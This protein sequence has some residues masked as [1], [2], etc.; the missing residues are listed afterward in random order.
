MDDTTQ[1]RRFHLTPG[2][3]VI[4]LLAVEGL[5]WLSDRFG[6]L[7]WH[8]GY[9]VLT[10]VASVGV[11]MLLMLVWFGVAVFFRRRFQFSIR[12]LLVLTVAVALPCSWL[13]VEMEKA[14]WQRETVAS[15]QRT[16]GQVYYEH[17]FD[18]SGE[19][20]P[21]GDVVYD[22][23]LDEYGNPIPGDEAPGAEKP[24]PTWL[25]QLLGDDFFR[26][27]VEASAGTDD[28]LK[29]VSSLTGLKRL[30]ID[31]RCRTV[32]HV[33][34]A[35]MAFGASLHDTRFLYFSDNSPVTDASLQPIEK[36][37]QLQEL[38]ILSPTQITDE[39]VAKLQQA[40]PD[41]KITR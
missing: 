37:A 13:G 31:P 7:A 21:L 30:M 18:S 40:L 9:A 14:E 19:R 26:T 25:R 33:P 11:A 16:G 36:S 34:E 23:A 38:E 22:N 8:K 3:F 29:L 28:G 35:V 10:A 12:T 39:G 2:R 27:A 24:A 6:W 5:L 17:Q 4:G 1:S 41:C 32:R 20:I 15:I